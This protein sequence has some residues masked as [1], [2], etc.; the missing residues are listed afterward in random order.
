MSFLHLLL[1][2]EPATDMDP[3]KQT[4]LNGGDEVVQAVH[5]AIDPEESTDRNASIVAE[6]ILKHSHDADAALKAFT[7][8][9]G[10]VIE[11]DEATNKRL[12]RIIDWHLMPVSY[13]HKIEMDS[14]QKLIPAIRKIMCV[15]YG[16]NYLDKTTLSYASIMGITESPALG[17]IGLHGTQYNWLGS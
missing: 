10:Q 6:K 12:L 11:I 1:L 4:A 14:R 3:E 8:H 5:D 9:Q 13:S 17:G 7:E 16:L 15:V 2:R